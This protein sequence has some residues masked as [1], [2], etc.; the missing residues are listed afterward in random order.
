MQSISELDDDSSDMEASR[1]ELGEAGGGTTVCFS[2]GFANSV[3][4]FL[5]HSFQQSSGDRLINEG[6]AMAEGPLHISGPM[7]T[8]LPNQVAYQQAASNKKRRAQTRLCPRIG[9][10][11][12]RMW[13]NRRRPWEMQAETW[14]VKRVAE[15]GGVQGGSKDEVKDKIRDTKKEMHLLP[16]IIYLYYPKIFFTYIQY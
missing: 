7:L 6:G 3:L 2:L 14:P 8:C 12:E 9:R 11:V 16:Y 4:L 10:A 1:R 15:E 13:V 5:H